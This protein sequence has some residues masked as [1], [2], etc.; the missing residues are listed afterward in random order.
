MAD[1]LVN[2][3]TKK[4]PQFL[5]KALTESLETMTFKRACWA[6]GV[7]KTGSDQEAQLL[8]RLKV[9]IAREQRAGNVAP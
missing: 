8:S 4:V 7:A 6:Y 9:V 2:G 1:V 5:V 3:K